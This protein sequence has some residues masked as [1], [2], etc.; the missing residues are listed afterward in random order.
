[1]CV[2]L[3]LALLA[4]HLHLARWTLV[5]GLVKRFQSKMELEDGKWE[6][7]ACILRETELQ[8]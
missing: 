5:I 8:N 6:S 2:H 7:H 1:M 4:V 3:G